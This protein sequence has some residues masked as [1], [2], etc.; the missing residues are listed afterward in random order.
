MAISLY[1]R[2]GSDIEGFLDDDGIKVAYLGKTPGID[3]SMIGKIGRLVRSFEPDVIHTHLYSLRYM[4]PTL[5]WRRA[6]S[7]TI[8]TLHNL[9]QHDGRPIDRVVYRFAFRHQRVIPVAIADAVRKSIIDVYG[10]NAPLIPNGIPVHEYQKG[11]EKREL[12]RT[13]HGI[14]PNDVVFVNLGRL[15]KQKNQKLILNAFA[16]VVTRVPFLRCLFVGDGELKAELKRQAA[17]LSLESKVEFLGLRFDV[18]DILAASDVGLLSSDWEGNPL[19][20][21]ETMAAGKPMVATAVGGVPELVP[22]NS[23]IVVQP[24][25]VEAFAEAMYQMAHAPEL[26]MRMGAAAKEFARGHFSAATMTRRYES[27]YEDALPDESPCL[28]AAVPGS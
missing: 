18:P 9:A 27:L 8:H 5:V 22:L 3:L 24:G 4:M 16:K 23:G 14:Q 10:L 28:P 11:L 2:R 7:V 25:N 21:M 6:K 1:E 20:V 15:S 13:Q 12:W 26:R 19:S 17:A